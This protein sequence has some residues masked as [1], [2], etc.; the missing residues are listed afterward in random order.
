M[1]KDID[2]AW[3][4]AFDYNRWDYWAS[5]ADDGW[6]AWC[7]LCGWIQSWIG[8]TEGLVNDDTSY[9]DATQCMDMKAAMDASLWMMEKR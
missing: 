7:T 2:G 9:W 8:V 1:H 3:F 4:R 6:G 5:N